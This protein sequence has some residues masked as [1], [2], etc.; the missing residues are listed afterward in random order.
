MDVLPLLEQSEEQFAYGVVS[1]ALERSADGN[2]ALDALFVGLM[3][4]QAAVYAIVLDKVKEY[5]AVDWAPLLAAF[6]LAIVGTALSIF[7]RDAPSL[8]SFVADFPDDPGGTR[9]TYIDNYIV[10][11]KANEQL[12]TAKAIILSIALVMTVIPLV[13]ATASRAGLF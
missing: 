9:R 4:A 8:R 2:H 12:R 7:V 11:A 13:I 3:A 6:I 5:P 1:R 10:K